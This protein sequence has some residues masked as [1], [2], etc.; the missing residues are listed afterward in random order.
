MAEFCKASALVYVTD[1][2]SDLSVRIPPLLQ[3]GV[4]QIALLVENAPK[5]R[6]LALIRQQTVL[7]SQANGRYIF[8]SHARYRLVCG[9]RPC[10]VISISGASSFVDG[11]SLIVKRK[12]FIPFS[13]YGT[14]MSY[15]KL[16]SFYVLRLETHVRKA[17]CTSS[18]TARSSAS[19]SL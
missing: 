3:G 1:R 14:S 10:D 2:F 18:I 12:P 19:P 13:A 7:V 15:T 8:G 9:E 6:V 17:H 4:V 16:L 5:R 11:I